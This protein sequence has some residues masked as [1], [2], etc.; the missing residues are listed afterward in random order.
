[1]YKLHCTFS[2]LAFL[3]ISKLFSIFKLVLMIFFFAHYFTFFIIL[4]DKQRL[5]LFYFLFQSDN[6][7]MCVYF[8]YILP[9]RLL[10]PKP[11]SV[12]FKVFKCTGCIVVTHSCTQTVVSNNWSVLFFVWSLSRRN[13]SIICNMWEQDLEHVMQ[14]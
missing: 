14:L 11:G 5:H 4:F 9:Y 10:F 2:L 6:I 3:T 1:M 12:C 7:N 8:T 13:I